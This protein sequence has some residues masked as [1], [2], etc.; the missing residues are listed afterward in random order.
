MAG[1]AQGPVKV[2][3]Q[4]QRFLQRPHE[5]GEHVDLFVRGDADELA[6]TI[7]VHGGVV[8]LAMGG[9][10]SA[11]VPVSEVN[12]LVSEKAIAGFEFALA[13]G[14]ALN[15]SMRVKCHVNEIH[16]GLGPLHEPYEGDGVLLG[17]IDTGLDLTHPDFQD[18]Q[19]RTRVLHLW[20]QNLPYDAQWTP[21]PYGYG[22][23][24]DSTSINAGDCPSID[25]PNQYGHG[26]TVAG[27]AGGNGL[28][29]GMHKG[30]APGAD[31]II[32]NN[33]L[34]HANWTSSV[35]DA[36]KYMCDI[37]DQLE[38][39]IAINLS[40]GSYYGSH[41]GL[42]AA[43]LLIDSLLNARPG[44]VLVCAAG[45]SRGLPPYHLGYPIGTDTS[46]TWF[47][48]KANSLLGIGAVYFEL[49]A[50]TAD[51]NGVHFGMSADR[52][53]PTVRHRSE[54]TWRT[55]QDAL[56]QQVVDT[57]WSFSG[58]RLG[59]AYYY[60]EL[61]GGQYRM[62]V[63]VPL[64]DSSSYYFRF[65]ATGT[66]RFDVWSADALGSSAIQNTV[67]AYVPD[68]ALYRYPDTLCKIVDSWACSD[69]VI[70]VGNYNN[71]Q[72]YIDYNG[73]LQDLG[74]VEGA[75]ANAS[76]NGPTRDG[77]IKPDV[78]ATGDVT[79]SPAPLDW[80]Q[81]LI[82]TEPFKVAPGGYHIRA[83]GT[84][85]ASPVVAGTA[86]LYL[87]KCPYAPHNEVRSAIINSAQGD[88]FTGVVPNALWGHGKL[89]AFDALVL[90]DPYTELSVF[91]DHDLCPGDS[92]LVS[93][94]GD[95][96][97]YA[98]NTGDTT[99][100]FYLHT[101]GPLWLISENASGCKAWTDT[102]VIEMHDTPTTPVIVQNGSALE[103]TPAF[104]YQWYFEN[105]PIGGADQQTYDAMFTGNY[106][107]QIADTN[108]CT[109]NS[110]TLFILVTTM[111]YDGGGASS[112]SVWPDPASDVLRVTGA[113]LEVGTRCAI[114]DANGR[115]VRRPRP[116]GSSDGRMMV[117]VSGLA[118]GR[119]LLWIDPRPTGAAV[120]PFT[121]A[122]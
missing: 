64:P 44:R 50:D 39:P 94:P 87:Q 118:P 30:V 19:G 32:V 27:T 6:R 85:I 12:A 18:A 121:I 105:T 43:A 119:Y 57:I 69:Q 8:K 103:S 24:F 63:A 16:Q 100:G 80:I 53:L 46:Y 47:R 41:D 5:P 35:T 77:R 84:S 93:G 11:S 107:V 99:K 70:T 38:R 55:V 73:A 59:E 111:Q 36:V 104:A 34:G 113:V 68:Q 109:A 101:G 23:A 48:Y 97:S 29:N 83:G 25:Q 110:D 66:G 15:D 13:P 28:A 49:W 96:V 61:R 114:L 26:T 92:V 72:V 90:S 51:L 102:I 2:G 22:Q 31:L 112:L 122:R 20:D 91:G 65:N 79:F 56:G 76:S 52:R 67:P 78:V 81:T 75:I 82:A 4:L 40:L 9:L 86:A 115:T 106:F 21:Q 7:A 89:N 71:E 54:P 58:D 37:A 10:V 33:D 98:W 88:A 108:G 14:R 42:D 62:D 60:A 3:L 1:H 74:G 120:L 45:N 95:M 116:G 117:D 17:I